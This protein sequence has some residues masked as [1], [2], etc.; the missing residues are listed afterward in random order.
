MST[1]NNRTLLLT[2]WFF[3]HRVIRWEHAITM[4]Y[5]GKVDAIVNYRETVRSPS[6]VMALPAVI[7]LRR[8]FGKM[9]LRGAVKFSRWNVFTRDGFRCQYCGAKQPMSNLT[10]DHVI[11]RACGGRT[12]WTNIVTA[13]RPCNGTKGSRTPDESGMFPLSEPM[14]PKS[15]PLTGP[16]IDI[17]QAPL[18]WRDFLVVTA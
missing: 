11:P 17:A 8:S 16:M 7:R 15:L 1:L 10:F 9:K 6:V 3:P 2:S 5:L 12:E 4:L 18:E 14:R 13:C